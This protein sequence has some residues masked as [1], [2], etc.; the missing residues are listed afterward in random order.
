[1]QQEELGRRALLI[2]A[3]CAALG[4]LGACGSDPAPSPPAQAGPAPNGGLVRT[5]D[6]PVGGGVVSADGVLVLQLKAGEFTAFDATCP[7]QNFRVQPPDSSGTITCM[8]HMSHFRAADGTVIDGPALG[9]GGLRQV[10]VKVSGAE[11]VRA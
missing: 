7:H 4:L 2:S 6:V 10:A 11:V 9:L 3:G 5:A 1:M 8:G